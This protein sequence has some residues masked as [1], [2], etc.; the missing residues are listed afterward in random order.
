MY[1][2]SVE[3]LQLCFYLCLFSMITSENMHKTLHHIRFKTQ[4]KHSYTY[5]YVQI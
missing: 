3:H 1:L 2:S 5:I 4:Q